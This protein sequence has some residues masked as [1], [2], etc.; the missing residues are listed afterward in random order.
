MICDTCDAPYHQQCHPSDIPNEVVN[1]G[2]KWVCWACNT[3][4]G[5]EAKR[6]RAL[7]KSIS[8]N[9][10]QLD[11]KEEFRNG[12]AYMGATTSTP[13]QGAWGGMGTDFNY[14][15]PKRE[16]ASLDINYVNA[17]ASGRPST[18]L[19]IIPSEGMCIVCNLA[20]ERRR[21]GRPSKNGIQA[22]PNLMD[23]ASLVDDVG[24]VEDGGSEAFDTS[25]ELPA[26]PTFAETYDK[27]DGIW[28]QVDKHVC[29]IC[30]EDIMQVRSF[31][32]LY[33]PNSPIRLNNFT[34]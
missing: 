25:M 10:S 29:Q 24:D 28:E 23:I 14:Q 9:L 2:E 12:P 26:Y 6:G 4:Q 30:R 34:F 11:K 27:Q 31:F 16:P 21:R 15:P 3:V 18:P 33:S 20:L 17:Y 1:S 22:T 8:T 13:E 32:L 5:L 19:T 7:T